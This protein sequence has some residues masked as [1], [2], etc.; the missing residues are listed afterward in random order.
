MKTAI[1]AYP[2]SRN[3]GDWIQSIIVT[4]LFQRAYEYIDREQLHNY[5]GKPIKLI[6]NGWFMENPKNWPPSDKIT[7]LF[8][9]FH[10]NPAVKNEMIQKQHLTYLKKYQPIGCRDYY[11]LNLLKHHGI[12]AYFSGCLTLC[13]SKKLL[14]IMATKTD[15]ILL[16]GCLDRLKPQIIDS[17]TL[18][19]KLLQLVKYPIRVL[20]YHRA[21][22][23]LSLSLKKYKKPIEYAS[24]VASHSSIEKGMTKELA[25]Q[26][27]GKIATSSLVITSRI[28]TALPA[29]ALGVPVLFIE[30]G[31]DHIN[32]Q[33]RINGLDKFFHT[34]KT[35]DLKKMDLNEI[36]PKKNHLKIAQQLNSR[37]L[38][39]LNS[40]TESKSNKS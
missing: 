16:V 32:H 19:K 37:I 31:L 30:D 21:N 28:H 36:Q 10:I 39:F 23:R 29:T 34:C 35:K 26:L 5:D 14:N 6:C 9:S 25:L 17:T 3:L 40:D 2:K 12:K 8:I 20:A 7:P 15:G 13:Y 33:S 18:S 11:T 24:Q 27:L 22:R 4:L 1:L 38:D